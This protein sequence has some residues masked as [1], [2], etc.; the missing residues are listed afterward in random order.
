[1]VC[2]VKPYRPSVDGQA[3]VVANSAAL[4]ESVASKF[5]IDVSANVGPAK[6]LEEGMPFRWGNET[7]APPILP[8]RDDCSG[9]A[10]MGCSALDEGDEV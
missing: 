3:E 6:A 9:E 2:S 5:F 10:C 8:N 4:D 1:M 7:V